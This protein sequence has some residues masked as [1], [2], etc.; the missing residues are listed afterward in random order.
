MSRSLTICIKSM[1]SK[2]HWEVKIKQDHDNREPP[3]RAVGRAA[4]HRSWRAQRGYG[5]PPRGTLTTLG[6]DSQGAGERILAR[7]QGTTL[8]GT[9][10][11]ESTKICCAATLK[12]R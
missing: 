7:D 3:G 11:R 1:N 5:H 8:H 10:S 9:L 2:D 4:C 6:V 12:Q